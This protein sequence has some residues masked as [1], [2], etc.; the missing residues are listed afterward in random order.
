[1]PTERYQFVLVRHA[2][3]SERKLFSLMLMDTIGWIGEYCTVRHWIG[4]AGT[5]G[6]I[7]DFE[8]LACHWSRNT[9]SHPQAQGQELKSSM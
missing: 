7:S 3:G 9:A 5:F 2:R 6:W 1:V 8:D 4:G